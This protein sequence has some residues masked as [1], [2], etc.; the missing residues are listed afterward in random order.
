MKYCTLIILAFVALTASAQTDF[1]QLTIIVDRERTPY[2][3][4]T[5]RIVVVEPIAGIEAS[6]PRVQVRLAPDTT[7]P[8]DCSID[9][10]S[11][12]LQISLSPDHGLKLITDREHRSY[13]IQPS[14]IIK[15]ESGSPGVVNGLP[16]VI[17]TLS[18]DSAAPIQITLESTVQDVAKA[19]KSSTDDTR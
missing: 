15:M 12:Q 14:R 16:T 19:L 7:L 4:Q 11:E 18:N 2:A 10:F 1:R 17:I 9:E 3:L 13:I 5:E 8:I 6:K